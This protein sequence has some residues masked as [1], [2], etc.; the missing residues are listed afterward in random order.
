MNEVAE[1][2]QKVALKSRDLA[3]AC[4]LLV[5]QAKEQEK[6]WRRTARKTK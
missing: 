3:E 6:R 5:K 4:R 1:C 2:W